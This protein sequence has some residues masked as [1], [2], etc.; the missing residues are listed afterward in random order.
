MGCRERRFCLMR[1]SLL[2]ITS[3]LCKT[4]TTALRV[5]GVGVY[6]VSVGVDRGIVVIL[7]SVTLYIADVD[8]DISGLHLLLQAGWVDHLFCGMLR[9]CNN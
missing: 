7:F 1:G 6:D 5:C 9:L 4:S 3:A 8:E 2:R